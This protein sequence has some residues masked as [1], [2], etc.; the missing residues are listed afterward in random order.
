ME[1]KL[2]PDFVV[3]DYPTPR[4]SSAARFRL[5]VLS[6]LHQGR[7]ADRSLPAHG[8]AV[9]FT[10]A[11]LRRRPT[12]S[13][14]PMARPFTALPIFVMRR[15]HHNGFWFDPDAGI[16]I[17]KDLEGDK[18]G[19]RAY[20]VTTGV[21]THGI[22]IDEYGLIPRRSPGWSTT[23]SMSTTRAAGECGS[24]TERPLAGGYDGGWRTR[25]GFDA[26][27]GIGRSGS[28]TGGWQV[29]E[30]AIPTLSDAE[31]LEGAGIA[32]PAFI[33]CTVRSSLRMR[34]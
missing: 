25:R 30:A 15:F 11:K 10:S 9:E 28:P 4:R 5:K 2:K 8:P 29:R 14:A 17:P 31:E 22:L 19:V 34:F 7:S 27:A 33:P 13:R 23:R 6:R 26:N 3:A 12:S 32:R 18:V 20:S 16:N 21:W 24:C 1:K